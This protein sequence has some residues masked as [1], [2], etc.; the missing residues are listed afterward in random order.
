MLKILNAKDTRAAPSLGFRRGRAPHLVL[1]Q[2]KGGSCAWVHAGLAPV[3]GSAACPAHSHGV[4]DIP[5]ASRDCTLRKGKEDE[6]LQAEL[7]AD[8]LSA[9]GR[10]FSTITFPSYAGRGRERICASSSI[11]FVHL[12]FFV[13]VLWTG[14]RQ[15]LWKSLLGCHGLYRDLKHLPKAFYERTGS[16]MSK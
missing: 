1:S 8:V 10:L 6:V 4:A 12:I 2:S 5:R 11:P 7:S 13:I 9:K 3:E 14:S 15:Q 16:H